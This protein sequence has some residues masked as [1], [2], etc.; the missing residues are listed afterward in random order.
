MIIS[1]KSYWCKILGKPV[2]GEYGTAW[3]FDLAI[4]ADTKKRLLSAGMSPDYVKNKSDDRGD[5]ITFKRNAVKTDGTNAKPYSVVGPDKTEWPQ[6]K[7]IGNGS[8]LN[9][10]VSL[11]E[12]K[13]KGKTKLKPSAVAVQVW[14]LVPFEGKGDGGFP[15][16][17]GDNKGW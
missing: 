3:S 15:T 13:Y 14:E 8:T 16:I 4:D 5:F 2:T 17:S 12:T 11:N 1:G 10:M 6:N 9:V 7:L